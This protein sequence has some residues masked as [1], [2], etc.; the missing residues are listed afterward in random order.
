MNLFDQINQSNYIFYFLVVDDFL[1]IALPQLK[2]FHLIY[3]SIPKQEKYLNSQNIP[4][5]VCPTN[6]I[7]NSGK[8]LSD[9]SVQ[10]YINSTA[11]NQQIVIIPFKPSA[12]IEFIC[13][14]NNWICAAVDHQLNRFL[15]D[16]NEFTLFCQKNNLPTVPSVI[17]LFNQN[18]FTKYQQQ[19][20]TDKLVIQTH[21]GWAGKS[22]FS[23]NNWEEIKNNI[24]PETKVKFSPFLE[25]YSLL[26]NCCLTQTGLI[27]SPPALQY[28]GLPEFTSNPFTTVGRQWPCLTTVEIQTQVKQIT[29]NFA[30]IIQSLSY[31]GF[32][33]LDFLV[34]HNQIYLLECNPRLTASFAFYTQIEINQNLD[35][36]FLFHLSQFINLP[37]VPTAS[38]T[39]SSIDSA[40]II[41]S[42]ITLKNQDSQ[43]IKKYHDF[44]P[45]TSELDP[46]KIPQNIINLLH[47]KG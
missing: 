32:F 22:T 38:E 46:I 41:G 8:L 45:F 37:S 13:R 33:G 5:F 18:N 21:F 35:P 25:G 9:I 28:T 42:E 47:E 1:D 40:K 31:K 27:Q 16:K 30:K 10:N 23:A 39:Q 3:S 34:S 44:I 20:Q 6:D 36:L 7:Q 12:K 29:A 2:N 15:E 26:N 14:Q 43:T 17:D 19:F 4:Y 24:P 11:N